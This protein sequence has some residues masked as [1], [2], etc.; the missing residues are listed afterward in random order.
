MCKII[1]GS[2]SK[3]KNKVFSL[4]SGFLLFSWNRYFSFSDLSLST[5][6]FF[7]PRNCE[8]DVS[9]K[10]YHHRWQSFKA[11]LDLHEV[12]KIPKTTK[13]GEVITIGLRGSLH[14]KGLD[15]P[16][17]IFIWFYIDSKCKRVTVNQYIYE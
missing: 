4:F 5:S 16:Q 13:A 10:R 6:I 17:I 9:R 3:F 12:V 14:C 11:S 8:E 1:K 2:C 15:C 7:K